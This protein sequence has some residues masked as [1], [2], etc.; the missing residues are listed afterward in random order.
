MSCAPISKHHERALCPHQLLNGYRSAI[1]GTTSLTGNWSRAAA[2]G[3]VRAL[4]IAAPLPLKLRRRLISS[5]PTASP[6][7]AH[8]VRLHQTGGSPMKSLA[9]PKR[10]PASTGNGRALFDGSPL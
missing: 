1:T 2:A 6:T 10:V 5:P 9:F 7:Q 3:V 4:D 8:E